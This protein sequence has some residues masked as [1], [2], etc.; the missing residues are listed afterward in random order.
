MTLK[1]LTRKALTGVFLV[2]WLVG[3]IFWLSVPIVHIVVF[4]IGSEDPYGDLIIRFN[5]NSIYTHPHFTDPARAALLDLLQ[6]VSPEEPLFLAA[7]I[8]PDSFQDSLIYDYFFVYSD[9]WIFP[10][11]WTDRCILSPDQPDIAKCHFP[12]TITIV[13]YH[14]SPP[15]TMSCT[16]GDL[17]LVL[18][19]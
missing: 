3:F 8:D 12:S 17:D 14:I 1:P 19:R 13:G 6:P 4:G 5:E 11:R 10:L 7:I 15:D 2:G 16:E 9:A 18:C